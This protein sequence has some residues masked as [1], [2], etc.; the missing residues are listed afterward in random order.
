ML[1]FVL[2]VSEVV[3]ILGLSLALKKVIIQVKEKIFLP[4]LKMTSDGSDSSV[5]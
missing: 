3:L 5:K 2:F 4:S 1:R